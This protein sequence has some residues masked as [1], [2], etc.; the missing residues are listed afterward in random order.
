LNWAAFAAT[1]ANHLAAL[2]LPARLR[3]SL[4]RGRRNAARRRGIERLSRRAGE[5]GV[6]TLVL[7]PRLGDFNEDLRRLGRLAA[8]LRDQLAPEDARLHLPSG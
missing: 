1:S 3:A 7:C 6:V 4:H 8:W 5:A 2:I